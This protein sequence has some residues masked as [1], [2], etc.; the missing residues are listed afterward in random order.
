MKTNPV[1]PE[2]IE[3]ILLTRQVIEERVAEL[4][5][6]ITRDFEGMDFLLLGVLKG[7]FVFMSDLI[8][9]LPM[10]LEVDFLTI[11]TYVGRTR[12]TVEPY[13]PDNQWPQIAGRNVLL[14][15]DILDSGRT[16]DYASREC[17]RRGARTFRVCTLMAKEGFESSAFP[18]PDYVGFVIPNLF[19][20]G[21]GLDYRERFRNLDCVGVL[22]QEYTRQG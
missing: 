22:S 11:S 10:P 5:A 17:L 7:A 8:R 18:N 14:V 21:Y 20:V 12:S 3:S 2:E 1:I 16:M 13:V 4:A 6:Q 15:E 9:R 19:V